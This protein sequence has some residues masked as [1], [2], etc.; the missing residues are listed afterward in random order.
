MSPLLPGTILPRYLISFK[1]WNCF[2]TELPEEEGKEGQ[3]YLGRRKTVV[4]GV[5][6]LCPSPGVGSGSRWGVERRPLPATEPSCP[7]SVLQTGGVT[8]ERWPRGVFTPGFPHPF[9]P[10][11]LS[12]IVALGPPEQA[13]RELEY[14]GESDPGREEAP[15]LCNP[16]LWV[17][18]AYWTVN[19][20]GAAKDHPMSGMGNS[21]DH[22]PWVP[23]GT[24]GL[25]G[26]LS[27]QDCFSFSSPCQACW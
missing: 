8:K 23:A 10:S 9:F 7:G 17:P 22:S 19:S 6:C 13:V 25:L 21:G 4:P 16:L 24:P 1:L 3:P 11:P 2:R 27:D 26:A 12:H 15:G 5:L 20:K 14:W 18:S